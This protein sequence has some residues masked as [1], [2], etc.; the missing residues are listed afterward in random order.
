MAPKAL[1]AD[2][3]DLSTAQGIAS[4]AATSRKRQSPQDGRTD[5]SGNF[6]LVRTPF[7]A[8]NYVLRLYNSLC[9]I[10]DYI[11]SENVVLVESCVYL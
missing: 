8:L 7:R 4:E 9:R 1:I 11:R 10:N 2:P 3:D 6:N 5:S